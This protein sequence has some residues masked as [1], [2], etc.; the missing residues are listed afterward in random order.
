MSLHELQLLATSV[1]VTTVAPAAPLRSAVIPKYGTTMM[2][3]FDSTPA[4][5]G[6]EPKA[7]RRRFT[8]RRSA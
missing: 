5:P 7:A 2:L 1:R 4:W 3:A 8:G 6:A